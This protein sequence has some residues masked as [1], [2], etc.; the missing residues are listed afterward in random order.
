MIDL[1][2]NPDDLIRIGISVLCGSIIGFER[3]YRNKSAGFRTIILITLGSTIFT[4]VSQHA[5]SSSNDRIASTVVTGIGFIGAGVIFKDGFGVSGLTTAAVIWIA[6]ALGMLIGIGYNS[7]A[8]LITV[9]VIIVLSVFYRIEDFIDI[10]HHSITFNITFK[11]ADIQH[12]YKLEDRI[13]LLQLKSNRIQISKRGERLLVVFRV[14]GNK[15]RIKDFTEQ[16]IAFPEIEESH[17]G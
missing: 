8:I 11:D 6:A 12:L 4:L 16:M 17:F 7:L 5:G 9:F 3:E 10:I 14:S 2:F 15:K 13:H 1:N